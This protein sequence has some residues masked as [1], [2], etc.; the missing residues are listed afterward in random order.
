MF[1]QCVAIYLTPAGG[2]TG[3]RYQACFAPIPDSVYIL[4]YQCRVLPQMLTV[5]SPWPLGGEA[6]SETILAACL[7]QVEMFN[8]ERGQRVAEFESRLEAS[9]SQDVQENCPKTLGQMREGSDLQDACYGED[10]I[11]PWGTNQVTYN[12]TPWSLL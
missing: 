6:H 3:Q 9:I 4:T 12:G 1:P 5:Q 7:A 8:G 10:R 11:L 2:T